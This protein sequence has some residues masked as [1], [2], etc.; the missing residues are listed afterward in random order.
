M[1][2]RTSNQQ[3]RVLKRASLLAC[4][5]L[6]VLPLMAAVGPLAWITNQGTHDVSVVDLAAGNVVATVKVGKAPAGI[7]IQLQAD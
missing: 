4:A 2:P 5:A 7:A 6:M 1:T 3:Q